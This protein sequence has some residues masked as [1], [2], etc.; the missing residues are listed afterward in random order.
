[1]SLRSRLSAIAR[2]AIG[3]AP[4]VASELVDGEK[5]IA[6][7]QPIPSGW[8]S[9]STWWGTIRESFAGAWQNNV[10]AVAPLHKI[11]AF[12]PIY[13]CV[14]IIG[15]DIAKLR[16]RLME[17]NGK[18]MQE[19]LNHPAFGPV[20]RK[21][22]H[23]QTRIQFL[24]DWITCK[25]IHGNT[26]VLKER[27]QRGVVVG[28]HILNPD[29]V[30]ILIAESGDVYYELQTEK[31]K[32]VS[33]SITVPATEIIHDRAV[34][35]FHPLVGVG[36]IYAAAMSATQGTKIQNNSA[37]FFENMSRPSGILKVLRKISDADAEKLKLQFESS[38]GGVNLGRTLITDSDMQYTAM[39]IPAQQA[40]LIEQLQWTIA[41][42]AR[43]FK[44]PLYKLAADSGVK[45]NNMAAQD[46][47][48]YK[49]TLQKLI[50]DVELLLGEG[51]GLEGRYEVQLDL[52]GLLRMDPV[53][54]MDFV[55][56]GVRSGV[57]TPNEGREFFDM[58]PVEGGNQCYMQQQMFPI[59]VLA[60]QPIP[61][62]APPAP[63]PAPAAPA[64]EAPKPADAAAK[65]A[66]TAQEALEVIRDVASRMTQVET[67]I[68]EQKELEQ[69]EALA[70]EILS[71]FTLDHAD[72]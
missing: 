70:A 44:V 1:M 50:E 15:D 46:G 5:G 33:N 60:K 9:A 65:A 51:L 52:S 56:K 11:L 67:L 2:A 64:L 12:S 43:P 21:P 8:G 22:N 61:N 6:G 27:D 53:Q 14:V 4:Q 31:L 25:L 41:D 17:R 7:T 30:K 72:A 13:A 10:V 58:P 39:S 29:R 47:D 32:L 34:C 26:Y 71:H 69:F 54:Q 18:I 40:Q 19:V 24:S 45:F 16:I 48:Y 66:T 62:S 37:G 23:Y 59:S 68:E 36:P 3:P 42:C 28:L 49:S 55:D 63:A 20:L 57:M 38:F 35:L